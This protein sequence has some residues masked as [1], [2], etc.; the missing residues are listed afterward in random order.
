MTGC[1]DA[2]ACVRCSPASARTPTR[3]CCSR[4]CA[5]RRTR[6]RTTWPRASSRRVPA[7]RACVLEELELDTEALERSPVARFLEQCRLPAA[8]IASTIELAGA[9]AASY[10][11]AL[12]RVARES[13]GVSATVLAPGAAAEAGAPAA[14]G[15]SRTG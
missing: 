9:I 2:S 1:S 4:G 13:M 11:S 10:G 8:D 15:V 5:K 3:A 12:V 7:G 6:S 14:M